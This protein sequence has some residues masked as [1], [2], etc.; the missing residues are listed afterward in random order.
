MEIINHRWQTLSA[1]E[2]NAKGN[3]NFANNVISA[4]NAEGKSSSLKKMRKKWEERVKFLSFLCLYFNTLVSKLPPQE[5]YFIFKTLTCF[6][7]RNHHHHHHHHHRNPLEVYATCYSECMKCTRT[8]FSSI[9][10]YM[11]AHVLEYI[12]WM[13]K[14]TLKAD[15]LIT[16]RIVK[17]FQKSKSRPIEKIPILDPL[18]FGNL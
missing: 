3:D 13:L 5:N 14:Y 9:L 17:T 18:D 11:T 2:I 16:K 8:S 7:T 6:W 12:S 15:V 10:L 1:K 4:K